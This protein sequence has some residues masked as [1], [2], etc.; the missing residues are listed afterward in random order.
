MI[1]YVIRDLAQNPETIIGQ[2]EKHNWTRFHI[3][4][5]PPLADG[6]R[7][8]IFFRLYRA[9]AKGKGRAI[10][11]DLHVESAYSK[12]DVPLIGRAPFGGA[13][14]MALGRN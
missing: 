12:G 5:K 2:T 7:Y 3:Y 14:E 11:I 6:K 13:I 8:Y 1:P 4:T 10:P 9:N